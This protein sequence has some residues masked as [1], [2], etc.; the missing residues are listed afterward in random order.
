MIRWLRKVPVIAKLTKRILNEAASVIV[1]GEKLRE[2]VI[3]RF[4][5]PEN[6]V[7]VMSMG[8]DT[9]I[10]KKM[11]KNNVREELGL[12]EDRN[13]ILFVG[14]IIREKGLVELVE[15]FDMLKDTQTESTLYLMGSQKNSVFVEELKSVIQKKV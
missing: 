7:E 14:N 5:V 12:E 13:I 10:F 11:S 3:G 6:R 1:V 9:S 2:D 8:V 4:A 15:A